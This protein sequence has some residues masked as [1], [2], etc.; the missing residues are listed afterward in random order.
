M[1]RHAALHPAAALFAV[2]AGVV[3]MYVPIALAQAAAARGHAVGLRTLLVASQMALITPALLALLAGGRS[4]RASLGLGSVGRGLAIVAAGAGIALWVTSVGLLQV[5]SLR[6]PP[7]DEFLETF[8]RL[9]EAL[10][11]RDAL[12]AA[13]SVIAIAIVPATCEEILFRGVLLPSLARV[14]RATAAVLASAALFG[15]IHL[16]ATSGGMAFTRI[17]FAILVGVGFGLLRVRS[18]SLVPSIAAHALLNTIT[19]AT[20]AATGVDAGTETPDA[21]LGGAMLVGGGVLTAL[22]LRHA[23][24]PLTPPGG[25]PRLAG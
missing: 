21:L 8:R 18:G 7:T 2:A 15:V 4:L 17:P 6:W 1:T 25:P 14:M 13:F 24:P 12:D 10:R 9:H 20:V 19:F 16:D 11:P 5:Q 23:R 22:A 3:A